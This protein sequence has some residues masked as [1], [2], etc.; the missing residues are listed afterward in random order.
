LTVQVIKNR[1]AYL[2]FPSLRGSKF[3]PPW[4]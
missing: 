4:Q 3:G 1:I 2:P